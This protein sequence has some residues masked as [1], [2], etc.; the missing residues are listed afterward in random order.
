MFNNSADRYKK[1]DV[2]SLVRPFQVKTFKSMDI[3]R[4]R[5]H[6]PKKLLLTFR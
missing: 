1:R 6:A 3:G 5:F 4:E 2:Q